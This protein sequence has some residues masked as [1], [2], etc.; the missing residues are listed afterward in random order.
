MK[1]E[2]IKILILFSAAIVGWIF[3][4]KQSIKDA[5]IQDKYEQSFFK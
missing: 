3:W 4:V 5:E 2:I 1:K